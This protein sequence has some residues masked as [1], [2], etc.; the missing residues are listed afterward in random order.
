MKDKLKGNV[1][2]TIAK[3]PIYKKVKTTR[4]RRKHK[5]GSRESYPPI[6]LNDP[7]RNKVKS[8]NFPANTFNTSKYSI[9]TFVPL[10]LWE[11]FR[12]ATTIYFTLIFIISA[13]PAISPLTPWT[14]LLGLLFI[15]V[16]AA[17][18]EG[19]EDFLRHKADRRVNQRR[20]LVL[21][22]DGERVVT[23]S[24]WLAVGN[25]V[26][27]RC[28]EQIPAD[29]VLLTTSS[30][31]GVCYIE[32]SQLDGETNLKLRK[33]PQATSALALP[34]LASIRGELRCEVPHHVLYS[35][36]GTVQ[37]E[38]EDNPI[39]L[40]QEQLLLQG[41]FLRNTDW[42][43]GVIAYA[44]PETK[45]SLNQKK[46]PFKTSRLDKRLNRYVLVLFA[47]NMLMCLTMG[48]LGGFFERIH[49]KDDPYLTADSAGPA[50]VGIK[51]FFAYFAL[52]SFLIPLSL[53][54]SLE[55]VKVIQA[56]FMEWDYEMSTER[57]HMTVKTSNLNDELALIKYVFSDKTGTLTENH[58]DFKKCT[59]RGTAYDEHTLGS[60]AD[61]VESEDVANFLLSM[62]V[63]HSAV[64]DHDKK[65]KELIYKASSPD[66]EALCR[67]AK[68]HGAIFLSR[69]NQGITV[70][71]GDQQL[72]FQ[73]LCMMEF[74]SERRRMS[75][76]VRTPEGKIKLYSKGADTM[77]YSLLREGDDELK[78]KI[79]DD[80]DNYSKEGLRTL[81][82]GEKELSEDE[83]DS[84][85]K[86]YNE[87]ANL[88]D[89]REEA[90][91]H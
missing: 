54:V 23:R 10:V 81:V 34:E 4:D 61:S 42:V 40:D 43:V 38:G 1:K 44:G 63:C 64:T 70:Q 35:F 25:M 65:T 41:S 83:C 46:P 6:Y 60:L 52:L 55:M 79:L 56:R 67:A 24:R 73:V 77:M 2:N 39:P 7:D 13:I 12:K 21:D 29:L 45:L 30:D 48:I 58:M 72:V 78:Q 62:A 3:N 36:K 47:I 33:A 17:V 16:V 84:F 14:S 22:A 66:E 71:I 15:L 85:L 87:A 74:T 90:V 53:V 86:A 68:D 57:G 11:Q 18:R 32:T 80:L 28:D 88:L 26:Y 75:V 50:V 20:Y 31:D 82:Y 89:G 37:I 69:S 8:N 76:L 9:I 19:W 91:R 5:E 59:I 27:V 49:A 51:L